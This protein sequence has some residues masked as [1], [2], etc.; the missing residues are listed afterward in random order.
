VG[1]GSIVGSCGPPGDV[2]I[3]HIL[4]RYSG[5]SKGGSTPLE[6]PSHSVGNINGVLHSLYAED[7]ADLD[8]TLKKNN[9]FI[10]KLP[11]TEFSIRP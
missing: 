4:S 3:G 9:E 6:S 8:L 2:P 5:V 7:V 11:S 1:V 10:G